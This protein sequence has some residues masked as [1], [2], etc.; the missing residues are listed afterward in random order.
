MAKKLL[1]RDLIAETKRLQKQVEELG[2]VLEETTKC[3]S[4][5]GAGEEA[6]KSKEAQAEMAAKAKF[7][8][9]YRDLQREFSQTKK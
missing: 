9:Q 8:G 7:K 5:S 4:S 3:K 2:E 1:C 6:A